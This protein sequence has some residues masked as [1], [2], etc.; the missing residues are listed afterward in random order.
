MTCVV[1]PGVPGDEAHGREVRQRL[2]SGTC[3]RAHAGHAQ[4][5]ACTQLAGLPDGGTNVLAGQ[6]TLESH[7]AV[8]PARYRRT[9]Q[10]D[11][12]S[13]GSLTQSLTL[14]CNSYLIPGFN[15]I[16]TPTLSPSPSLSYSP[17]RNCN[18]NHN[19]TLTV[20]MMLTVCM[21]WC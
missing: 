17:S 13:V 19:L 18:C 7:A 8:K 2:A 20:I 12:S 21:V 6:H 10:Y 1:E 3:A 16:P 15:L 9:W 4:A 11:G 14:S 5:G